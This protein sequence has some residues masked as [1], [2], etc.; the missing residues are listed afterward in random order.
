M[1]HPIKILGPLFGLVTLLVAWSVSGAEQP[2]SKQS[3]QKSTTSATETHSDKAVESKSTSA[4]TKVDLNRASLE[5]LETLPGIGPATAQAIMKARPFRSINELT[6]VAGIGPAK[7]TALK[8]QV[9]ARPVSAATGKAQAGETASR[10]STSG[11][12]AKERYS[13][14][15]A[16]RS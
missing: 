16:A 6:N 7:F 1:H 8:S 9:T 4:K 3:K 2:A 12:N 13:A 14:P 15:P 5:E 11:A 10:S